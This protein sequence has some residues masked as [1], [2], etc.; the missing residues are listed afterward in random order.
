MSICPICKNSTRNET[1]MSVFHNIDIHGC[2]QIWKSIKNSH[3][4][5]V[6]IRKKKNKNV[7]KVKRTIYLDYWKPKLKSIKEDTDYKFGLIYKKN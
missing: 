7:E 6:Q 4:R 3:D 2:Y 1:H 5:T